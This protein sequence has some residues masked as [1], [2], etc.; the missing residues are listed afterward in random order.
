MMAD[1]KSA[2]YLRR[3]AHMG[4]AISFHAEGLYRKPKLHLIPEL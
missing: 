3:R 2:A 1:G 4:V